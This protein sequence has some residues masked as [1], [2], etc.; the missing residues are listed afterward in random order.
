MRL[1]TVMAA[2]DCRRNENERQ[3]IFEPCRKIDI[4]MLEE[5]REG[6]NQFEDDD[7]GNRHAQDDHRGQAQGQCE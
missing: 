2:M 1:A 6:E 7:A 5:I 3:R 4:A